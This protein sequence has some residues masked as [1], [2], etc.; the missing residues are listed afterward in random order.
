MSLQAAINYAP[1]HRPRFIGISLLIHGAIAAAAI[2][3]TLSLKNAQENLREIIIDIQTAPPISGE[4][5]PTALDTATSIARIHF[6]PPPQIVVS[7][8]PRPAEAIPTRPADRR[9]TIDQFRAIHGQPTSISSKPLTQ[10]APPVTRP[11]NAR[12]IDAPTFPADT[13]S[14][15]QTTPGAPANAHVQNQMDAYFADLAQHIREAQEK[16]DGLSSELVVRIEF[17]VFANGNIGVVKIIR[18][19]G[20]RAFDDSVLKA[21]RAVRPIGARPDGKS[22]AKIADFRMREE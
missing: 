22:D 15:A 14:T 9:M 13:L 5:I 7:K 20:N 17:Q 10:I 8:S 19:S 16:P 6:D 12:P 1:A 18:S 21:I 2:L 11:A 4:S 3:Y